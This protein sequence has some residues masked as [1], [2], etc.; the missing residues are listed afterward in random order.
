ME[1]MLKKKKKQRE[2][3]KEMS[4]RGSF[5]P[6]SSV[7]L[8]NE[9]PYSWVRGSEGKLQHLSQAP[10][11]YY[12]LIISKFHWLI[13]LN[14]SQEC[15]HF[16][17]KWR[18]LRWL[19][20]KA[21]SCQCRKCRFDPWVRNIPWRRKWQ[22]IPV[23]LPGKSHWQRSLEGYSPWGPQRVGHNWG[24]E[25]M[26]YVHMGAEECCLTE[27][28][29]LRYVLKHEHWKDLKQDC[30]VITM[31]WTINL[32]CSTKRSSSFFSFFVFPPFFPTCIYSFSVYIK[33]GIQT[34]L[35]RSTLENV[36][37]H[38]V[39]DSWLSEKIPLC[40]CLVILIS[41]NQHFK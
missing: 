33:L 31:G 1:K 36:H 9:M 26:V 23:F 7:P 14:S 18:L 5:R 30:H 16:S 21:S 4:V 29:C 41:L 10:F 28:N 34:K 20:G 38:L 8:W 2:R 22:P 11:C 17:S 24:T 19:K 32:S 3:D 13:R 37:N 12:L 15:L 6:P 27:I 25:H 35:K 39:E 40:N